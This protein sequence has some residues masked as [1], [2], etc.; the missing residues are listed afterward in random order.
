MKT[1]HLQSSQHVL[2]SSLEALN[3][4]C[5]IPS[6]TR[7]FPPSDWPTCS[8]LQHQKRHNVN[9]YLTSPLTTSTAQN[10]LHLRNQRYSRAPPSGSC[11]LFN[12]L[13]PL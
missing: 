12:P 9:L 2:I 1:L 10:A 11:R 5:V 4:G 3:C 6:H 8:L 7:T 13:S